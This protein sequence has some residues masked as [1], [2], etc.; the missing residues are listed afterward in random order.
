MPKYIFIAFFMA[1]IST[2]VI[3]AQEFNAALYSGVVASQVDGDTYAGYNKAGLVLGGYVNRF[4]NKKLATQMGMRYIQKGSKEADD[5]INTYYMIQL[6]YIEMPLTLRYYYFDKVDFE[7]GL[8]LGYLIKGLEAKN[9]DLYLEEANPA[10]DSFDISA[11]AG[12]SYHFN[13]KLS[14]SAHFVYSLTAIRPFFPNLPNIKGGQ[15]N[16]VLHFTL[17]Y[18]LSSWK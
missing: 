4:L 18:K 6:H 16:N 13:D 11:M 14:A 10:F 7:G 5:K 8:A 1:I 9:N 17:A 15:Y 12:L 3:S 2:S